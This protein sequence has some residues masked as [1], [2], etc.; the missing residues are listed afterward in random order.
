MC[1]CHQSR[2]PDRALTLPSYAG[3]QLRRVRNAVD[4]KRLL[5]AVHTAVQIGEAVLRNLRE[6]KAAIDLPPANP[7]EWREALTGGESSIGL[8]PILADLWK[9]G[10]P[11]ISLGTLPG[12]AF[13]G[14]SCIVGGHPIICLGYKYDEPGRL[15]FI[16]AHEVAH[17]TVGDCLTGAPLLHEAAGVRD[18]SLQEGI[19]D[20]FA[21]R[22]LAGEDPKAV[23]EDEDMDPKELAQRA[24][25]LEMETGADASSLIYCWAAR[26]LKYPI[27]EMAVGALYRSH[28]AQNKV[29]K[30]ID[31]YVDIESAA[32][33]DRSLLN[34]I[35]G[36][37][38]AST[39]AI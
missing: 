37:Q 32:E 31:H 17:I 22:V 16:V 24:F 9:R 7:L 33:S 36:V 18:D 5:P 21:N 34:C 30:F 12:P 15:A 4:T 14:M 11:V 13:Q 2:N 3:A 35:G 20:Q 26:T 8:E 38:Q 25:D 27:A 29:R 10:I 39:A 19:A 6:E 23:I 28:G 1:L